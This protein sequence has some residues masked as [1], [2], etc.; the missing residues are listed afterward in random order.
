MGQT[1][2]V[3]NTYGTGLFLMMNTGPVMVSSRSGL[4]TTVA[5]Q[6]GKSGNVIYALEGSVSH[7]GS[8]L[9]WLRDK[10][11]ILKDV[12]DSE[13]MA[14]NTT[15][16]DGLYLVPAFSGLFAPY[17][18][19]DA[20]AC[21]VGI[22]INHTYN[23]LVRA[24]LEAAAYQSREV[25]EAICFDSNMT[26]SELR[27]DGGATNNKFLMQFQADI[28]GIPLVRSMIN[29]TTALG[30]A[31]AAGLAV[32]VWNDMSE[33]RSLL[34]EGDTYLPSMLTVDRYR[35]WTGWQRAVRKSFHSVNDDSNT[36]KYNIS[37]CTI[38]TIMSLITALSI[39]YFIGKSC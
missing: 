37:F 6:I 15:G 12:S 26:L 5:Y 29:E 11:C 30:V 39:G 36:Q 27:V 18:R 9:S 20:R 38:S 23:H 33:L 8:T 4:L 19:S 28:I 22:T 35:N 16:N 2:Q 3:K 17:W 21:I 10:L 31:F 1:G 25:F 14:N 7:S 34:L 24:A 13:K 32:G